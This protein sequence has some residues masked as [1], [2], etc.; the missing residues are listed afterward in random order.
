MQ[1]ASMG[2]SHFDNILAKKGGVKERAE[3][4]IV[5]MK[6]NATDAQLLDL[7]KSNKRVKCQ[8]EGGPSEGGVP[9]VEV[10]G[11]PKDIEEM[12]KNRAG[13]VEFIEPNSP[14]S[15]V[16]EIPKG[17]SIMAARAA[18]WGLDR[19]GVSSA[20]ATGKGVHVYV[21]DTG[22]NTQHRD[23]GGRGIPTLDMT[24]G[25]ARECRGSTACAADK[26]GHGTHCAGTTSG[27]T[28]GVAPDSFVHAVKVLSDEGSGSWGWTVG[29][30]DWVARSGER[31]AV[32]S[33]SLGGPGTS[34]AMKTAVEKAVQAGVTVVVAAGNEN[35]DACEFSPAFVRAAVTVGSTD[36]RDSR[37]SFSN[38]GSCVQIYAPGTDITSAAHNS[39]TGSATMSGTSMACPHVSGS[40]ALLLE[41]SPNATPAQIEA[42][43]TGNSEAGVVKGLR[44]GCPNKLLSVGGSGSVTSPPSPT[45]RPPAP[46][47]S[48]CDTFCKKDHCSRS[49]PLFKYCSSCTFCA[50]PPSTLPPGAGTSYKVGDR[51]EVS[52]I[53]SGPW[54]H[55]TV[56]S[57]NPLMA[58]ADGYS[59]AFT[60][61]YVR[62]KLTARKRC[63]AGSENGSPDSTGDCKCAISTYCF[64]GN[65]LGCSYSVSSRKSYSY[66]SVGCSN[67]QCRRS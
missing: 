38:Y 65:S 20:A 25:S 64:T 59:R 47:A 39:N 16:P 14:V 48:S 57:L 49:S 37:S 17:P 12:L 50:T 13:E 8:M 2:G 11:T 63:P 24:S 52:D 31:P 22:I 7:C 35:S 66:F 26:Q 36:S 23:F 34:S 62:A 46:P 4:W 5:M 33:M 42:A 56:A 45:P 43:L 53:A 44:S 29:A 10:H 9:F 58:Q 51:V 3:D 41:K 55:A 60:W 27:K 21:L 32:V 40:A 28:F 61:K 67:C 18:S 1:A 6:D 30:L 15:L 54:M 19:I